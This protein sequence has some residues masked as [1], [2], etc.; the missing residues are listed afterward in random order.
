LT[1]SKDVSLIVSGSTA[2]NFA[3]CDGIEQPFSIK[4]FTKGYDPDAWIFILSTTSIIIPT[5]VFLIGKS[6]RLPRNSLVK[7]MVD[8]FR[9][10]VELLF[11]VSP[12]ISETFL[13]SLNLK[14]AFRFIFGSL[15]LG[16]FVLVN[17]YKGLFTSFLLAPIS[18]V[19]TWNT[20]EQL[21]GFYLLMPAWN[22]P[23]FESPVSHINSIFP[24]IVFWNYAVDV[25]HCQCLEI[26]PRLGQLVAQ[27][28]N[29]TD[30][31]VMCENF[32]RV[33]HE[34]YYHRK[35]HISIT[36][37]TVDSCEPVFKQ[38]YTVRYGDVWFVLERENT[39]ENNPRE[40]KKPSCDFEK[41]FPKAKGQ[42][43]SREYLSSA[44]QEAVAWLEE[45]D[46]T[47]YVDRDE[48]VKG[49]I[50]KIQYA[51]IFKGSKPVP[52]FTIGKHP[53]FSILRGVL[54]RSP[55]RL[56]PG[57]ITCNRHIYRST[58][59]MTEFGI[60]QIWDG[61]YE[62]LF[63]KTKVSIE[64]R[65]EAI[66]RHNNLPKKMSLSWNI[67]S[68]FKMW[69]ITL[70]VSWSCFMFEV[71]YRFS[72]THSHQDCIIWLPPKLRSSCQIGRETFW[73]SMDTSKGVVFCYMLL[74]KPEMRK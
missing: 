36:D 69:A 35:K 4:L 66:P 28:F 43:I 13:E 65:Q 67:V 62:L 21:E 24:H 33:K 25:M 53:H 1:S 41:T 59:A 34:L 72:Q 32:Q 50:T 54:F 10:S 17:A 26:D 9:S 48:N 51:E 57:C 31:R 52:Y 12:S 38:P 23:T 61:S 44:E 5:V 19:H 37:A 73:K 58:Q 70:T 22:K 40:C 2:F 15:L 11:D 27:N 47:A 16:F 56:W 42:F 30:V 18:A 74:R 20:V 71:I 68:I 29:K 6:L 64:R 45:C 8:S 55:G 46:K 3:T 49:F 14:Y 7:L 39:N 60:L 63:T